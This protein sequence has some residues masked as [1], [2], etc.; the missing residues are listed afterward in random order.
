M[1]NQGGGIARSSLVAK[2][3]YNGVAWKI[4]SHQ[5]NGK[6]PYILAKEKLR[7]DL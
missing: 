3:Y 5:S 7:L 1:D 6:V 2:S 4:I